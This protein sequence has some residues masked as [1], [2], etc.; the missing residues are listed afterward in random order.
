MEHIE[1]IVVSIQLNE[2]EIEL[3]ELI[4]KVR[5]FILNPKQ[6]NYCLTGW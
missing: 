1:K 3:G 5:R 6:I 4:S 2:E